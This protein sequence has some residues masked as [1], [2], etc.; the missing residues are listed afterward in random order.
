MFTTPED[1]RLRAIELAIEHSGHF[2]DPIHL[3]A[4]IEAFLIGPGAAEIVAAAHELSD[5]VSVKKRA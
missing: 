2:G 3:A 4:K 5:V 1:R